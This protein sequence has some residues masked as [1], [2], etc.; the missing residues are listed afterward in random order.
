[1]E[2]AVRARSASGTLEARAF[3]NY[4]S[5]LELQAIWAKHG[6]YRLGHGSLCATTGGELPLA[7]F[8]AAVR[9]L[10]AGGACGDAVAAVTSAMEWFERR[11]RGF[12]FCAHCPDD[13]DIAYA[14][15]RRGFVHFAELP[16][17]ALTDS[18]PALSGTLLELRQVS[19]QE[20]EEV[21]VQICARGYVIQGVPDRITRDAFGG[22]SLQGGERK[23][24]GPDVRA[25]GIRREPGTE[26]VLGN[27][28][29]ETIGAG[30]ILFDDGVAGLYWISV[31]PEH[32]RKG[33][34]VALV[35]AM[36][37]RARLRGY[38]EIVLQS[39]PMALGL[40]AQLGFRQITSLSYYFRVFRKASGPAARRNC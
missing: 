27:V 15:V 40:Y 39:S 22:V 19:T 34:G 30:L 17:L 23:D 32:R 37:D 25:R 24:S 14:C 13:A 18:L 20:D 28:D 9:M 3:S 4:A 35:G 33:Y 6:E 26:W 16:V 8:N 5:S 21:F 31:L 12:T 29:G 2:A 7:P 36:V 1:M 11:Q 10:D 38:D